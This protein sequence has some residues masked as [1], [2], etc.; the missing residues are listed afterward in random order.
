MIKNNLH[1]II[2]IRSK[3]TVKGKGFRARISYIKQDGLFRDG[4]WGRANNE[5][6][7]IYILKY[8]KEIIYV[9]IT[10]TRLSTRFGSGLSASGK[11]GYHGYAWKQLGIKK[12]S[13]P[14]DLFVYFFENKERTEAIEAE[15]VYLV[16]HK[17]GKWPK[18]QTEIHF[19][20]ANTKEKNIAKEI[21][22]EIL[23]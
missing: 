2:K 16:R 12:E 19:H 23:K 17:T 7:K 21:F 1:F 4:F 11:R 3:K 10:T 18:Y 5:S 15:I 20:Q 6:P 22:T 8:N 13:D 14:I 9:G